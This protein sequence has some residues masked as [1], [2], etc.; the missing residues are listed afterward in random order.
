M[1]CVPVC[2][3]PMNQQLTRA[4]HRQAISVSTQCALAMPKCVMEVADALAM[5]FVGR[6]FITPA[7]SDK[8]PTRLRTGLPL[9]FA[10]AQDRKKLQAGIH[11]RNSCS[12]RANATLLAALARRCLKVAATGVKQLCLLRHYHLC[13][14]ELDRLLIITGR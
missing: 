10:E 8:L 2:H 7:C 13:R 3:Q 12:T 5:Q 4:A 9:M 1:L 6:L 11:I 14:I